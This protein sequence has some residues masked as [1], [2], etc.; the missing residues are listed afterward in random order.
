[1]EHIQLPFISRVTFPCQSASSESLPV[2]SQAVGKVLS[3]SDEIQ[4]AN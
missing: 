1:M 2:I 4:A 3:R